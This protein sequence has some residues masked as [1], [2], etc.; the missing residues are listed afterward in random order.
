MEVM[1]EGGVVG[2]DGGGMERVSL[3][4]QLYSLSPRPPTALLFATTLTVSLHPQLYSLPPRPPTHAHSI[5]PP[6]A[7]PIAM[8][9]YTRLHYIT[10]RDFNIV[11]GA[12]VVVIV[13]SVTIG[14]IV[15]VY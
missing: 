4:P 11:V 8:P 15:G 9:P 14:S 3:H 7:L 1:V 6:T 10:I 5:P 13:A 2:G 12:S